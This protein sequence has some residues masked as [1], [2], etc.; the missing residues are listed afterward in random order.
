MIPAWKWG[1]V[2]KHEQ[3]ELTPEEEQ[4]QE[5]VRSIWSGILSGQAIEEHTDF[6]KSGA[7]SMDVTRLL[8]E[9]R[10]MT[11][12]EMENDDAYMNST[13]SEF[14]K[15]LVLLTRGGQETELE[16]DAVSTCTCTLYK[17]VHVHCTSM[18]TYKLFSTLNELTV[19]KPTVHNTCT[20]TP[21]SF[22]Y[23][24][25]LPLPKA[26]IR[27]NNMEIRCPHQCFINNEF[28]DASDGKTYQ[29]IN[30]TDESAICELAASGAEDVEK[31]IK[32]AKVYTEIYCNFL[33]KR[34]CTY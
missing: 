12:V 21:I 32:A 20:C 8:E 18:C 14:V 16:Y 5:K 31:A 23:S 2:E 6:F 9:I 26:I 4:L 1:K 29:T 15:Q 3:L 22:S 19:S 24:F 10:E 17:H 34:Q 11:G 7:G 33:E 25:P 27:A 13:F 30:P 28:I